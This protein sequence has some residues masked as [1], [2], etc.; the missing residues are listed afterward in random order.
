VVQKATHLDA[1]TKE[2]MIKTPKV[3]VVR[4]WGLVVLVA[5]T[6]VWELG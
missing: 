3:T 2:N 1:Q 4:G 6:A 5:V